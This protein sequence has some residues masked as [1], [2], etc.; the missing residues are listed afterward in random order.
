MEC[1]CMYGSFYPNTEQMHYTYVHLCGYMDT[2][3][4]DFD[5]HEVTTNF[6]INGHITLSW[7]EEKYFGYACSM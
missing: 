2:T 4:Q 7:F 6:S 5:I 1:I 3:L